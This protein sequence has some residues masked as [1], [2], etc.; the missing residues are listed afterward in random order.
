MDRE[1]KDNILPK[2]ETMGDSYNCT[3]P[4]KKQ[5]N[6]IH[7]EDT[8]KPRSLRIDLELESLEYINSYFKC[9]LICL[10]I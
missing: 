8:V 4:A 5:E 6:Q 1:T 2:W 7:K 10:N 3:R 9:Y